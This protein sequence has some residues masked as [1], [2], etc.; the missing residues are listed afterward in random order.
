MFNDLL[1]ARENRRKIITEK[2]K[3]TD[4][5]SVKANVVGAIKNLPT[6]KLLLSYF[7]KRVQ[8]L[9]VENLVL[10]KNT[11]GDTAIGEIKDG[12]LLKEKTVFI[13]E[14]DVLG[15]FIDIDV[16]LKGQTQSLSRG[17][18][19]KCFLCSN[20][21]FVCGK[22]KTHT[23]RELL[24]FFNDKTQEEIH[25]KLSNIL[26]E[27]LFGE[28]NLEN[29]FGL[30]TPTDNGSHTDLNYSV[31]KKSGEE[32]ATI[33]PQA[34]F[35]GLNAT[36]IDSLFEKLR[37]VGQR[38]EKVMLS[39][40]NGANAY[41]GFIFIAC[42]LLGSMGYVI[43]NHLSYNDIYKTAKEICKDLCKTKLNTFGYKAHVDGFGGIRKTAKDGFTVVDYAKNLINQD[44]LLEVLCKIVGKIDD[45]VLLKRAK[46]KEKY[47]Y[48]KNL[49]SNA[50]Y[51]DQNALKTLTEKCKAD[52]ISI[53]GSADVLISALMMKKLTETFY[54]WEKK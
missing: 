28:L 44:N 33:L 14:N 32:I 47:D 43:S 5:V 12:L 46:S 15:R 8:D 54:F 34:F 35:V 24:D 23:L 49:I 18:L 19:R 21:A 31:M 53:G 51:N 39:A 13:E 45:S 37:E 26:K 52:N 38:A 4:V 42:V 25:Q 30:V 10:Y 48:Y 40:T 20:P 7:T 2:T 29:K 41:K 17:G 6:S 9:G 11:D 50:D 27:S 36:E 1:S 3:T 16:T 22:N